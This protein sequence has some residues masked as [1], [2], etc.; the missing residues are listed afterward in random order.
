MTIPPV[1]HARSER[2]N[3]GDAHFFR[4]WSLVTKLT[5]LVGL[6]LATLIAALLAAGFYFGREN[7]R[8]EI[9]AHLS[10]VAVSRQDMVLAHLSLLKQRAE[11]LAD[12]GE[13]RA[14]MHHLKAGQPDT[15]NQGYSQDRL[16]RLVD[17]DTIISASI[18]DWNGRVL[19]ASTGAKTGGDMTGD[20]AFGRG[21]D[22][23]FVGVPFAADGRFEVVLAAPI[24]SYETPPSNVAV[25]MITADVSPLAAAVRDTTGLGKTGEVLLGVR[26]GNSIRTLF[27]PR[28]RTQ[29]VV[30]PLEKLPAMDAAL[31]GR[32]F[33][34]TT[35][36]SSGDPVLAAALPVGYGGWGLVTK[37]DAREAYAPIARTLRYILLCGGA[38]AAV[39]LVAAYLLARSIARPVQRLVQAAARVAGGQYDTPVPVQSADEFGVLTARFNEMTAAIR[40]RGLERD[41]K[42]AALRTSELRLKAIGDHLPGST[43]YEYGMRPDGTDFFV[44]LSAGI[45]RST[46]YRPEELIVN[47]EKLYENVLEEDLARMLRATQESAQNLTIFDQ[48]VRRQMP[49]GEI[50]WFHSRSMPRRLE[51]GSTL[52]DGVERDVTDHKRAEEALRASDER[53]RQV[54]D[55]VPHFIFAKDTDGRFLFANRAL[56][57]VFGM[58]PEEM[59]GRY[60]SDLSRDEEEVARFRNGDREVMTSGVP[61]FISEERHT[62]PSGRVRILQTIKV[63]FA[64]PG[65]AQPG[66]LG[67]SMDITERKHAEEQ[68]QRVESKLLDI[69]KLES[70]G[71]LAGGIAHD[72]NNLLTGV[73]GNASLARMDLPE[74]SPLLPY[75]DEIEQA[76]QHAAD[77]CRQMLAY[78]GKGRFVLQDVHLSTLVRET[79]HLLESS[80]VKGVVLKFNLAEDLPAVSADATQL[81]QVV[82]N[83]VINASEAIGSRSGTVHIATVLVNADRAYLDQTFLALE[84]PEGH[85]VQLEVSDNGTGMTEETISKIFDPFFTT[86]FTGRGLGLAAVLG[87]VRGHK[88]T[89][90]VY[91][92]PGKGTSFKILLPCAGALP[93]A[94]SVVKNAPDPWR[95]SGTVLLVDDEE[96]V[97]LTA[98]RMLQ[99]FGFTVLTARDGREAIECFRTAPEIR[100]VLLDLTMP[101]LDGE[102]TFRELR[103]LCPELRVVLMSGFN[104]HEA[105]HRFVGQGLAGF[106]QKPFRVENLR[107]RMK[108]ILTQGHAVPAL[109]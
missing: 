86:K 81:R 56:A 52:W 60:D 104:E 65:V 59:V 72:F 18:V 7:L 6:T 5:I 73:I 80:I 70:L 76:A 100:A 69:Q 94:N 14:L 88:G 105:S 28:H 46:T 102:G 17:Q 87:I 90:K 66:V 29:A 84:L 78:A 19:L 9:D 39:G 48:Q 54:M 47:P 85:Y 30:L 35:R 49:D 33:L 109:R 57:E 63:P 11:L 103:L 108:E 4:R 92:E 1:D 91:S 20:P 58:T 99:A 106:L 26:E 15:T 40:S 3:S 95:G 41:A 68:R 31:T 34:G 62:D 27:P 23:P 13:F 22:G 12:H 83:L 74:A 89:L 64:R 101:H 38:V 107:E 32:K 97:R 75:L 25:L 71:V 77:L 2:P 10:S 16:D 44:Y 50:R 36:D 82:M 93:A 45:E 37:M 55:V 51:D 67:V 96:T 98:G 79:T 21:L 61:R 42:E 8:E 24:R 43:I 53:L